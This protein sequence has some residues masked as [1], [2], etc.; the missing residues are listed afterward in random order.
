MKKN[1]KLRGFTLLELVVTIG[2]ISLLV[3]IGVPA[4]Y[5][6]SKQ[7][8]TRTSAQDIKNVL[9][10]A[11]SLSKSPA[12]VDSGSDFYYV[13]IYYN[14]TAGNSDNGKIKIGRGKFD[15][16]AGRILPSSKNPPLRPVYRID[17][18]AWITDIRP[19]D[20]DDNRLTNI[21]VTYYYLIPSGQILFNER[22]PAP[23]FDYSPRCKINPANCFYSTD[24][25]SYINIRTKDVAGSSQL[26][27][28]DQTIVIDGNGGNVNVLDGLLP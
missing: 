2:I 26:E 23:G 6:Y 15:P 16:Q 13:T 5:A 17:S 12:A 27:N 21:S 10:E 18:D 22:E 8:A 1:T 20:L 25:N 24:K 3:A 7:N 28:G 9:L 19:K 4:F 14:Q 11:Q